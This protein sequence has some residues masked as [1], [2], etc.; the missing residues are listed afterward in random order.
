MGLGCIPERSRVPGSGAGGAC[1]ICQPP[2]AFLS[3]HVSPQ[4]SFPQVALL[5]NYTNGL[6]ALVA[7]L[8]SQKPLGRAAQA[9]GRA[10]APAEAPPG[11]A[12]PN[13]RVRVPADGGSGRVRAQAC[14]ARATLRLPCTA[15]TTRPTPFMM[16]SP[17]PTSP[18]PPQNSPHPTP[19][20]AR[21]R[22]PTGGAAA[23]AGRRGRGARPVGGAVGRAT[24]GGAFFCGSRQL[25]PSRRPLKAAVALPARRPCSSEHN[26]RPPLPGPQDAAGGRA[27][28]P[29]GAGPG[30]GA[31]VAR[32]GGG[33]GG[34]LG[35]RWAG[36][37]GWHALLARAT[38]RRRAPPGPR[39]LSPSQGALKTLGGHPAPPHPP[40]PQPCPP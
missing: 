5:R 17:P 12:A 7:T 38:R 9:A 21:H 19:Q 40:L 30:R 6:T 15:S 24:F 11:E 1:R 4:P 26:T 20:G 35:R 32:G 29:G 27:G 36:S 37:T 3:P 31:A 16:S 33:E 2:A 13:S 14:S 22:V 23:G 10:A 25:G 18:P 34:R 8:R 39:Y 28:L